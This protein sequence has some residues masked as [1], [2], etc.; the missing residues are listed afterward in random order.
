[1]SVIGVLGGMGPAATVDFLAKLV[2]LT[3]ARRDQEHLPVVVFGNP[4]IPDRSA[5]ILQ[6][7]PNPLPRLLAGIEFLNRAGVGLIAIPCNSSHHWY[8]DLSARSRVPILHIAQISVAAVRPEADDRVAV[9][10]TR[11]TIVSGFYARELEFQRIIRVPLDGALQDSVDACIQ[12]VKSGRLDSAVARLQ[13]AA[14]VAA[15]L[16]AT[17]L[18]MGCTE[19][20]VAAEIAG[21]LELKTVDSSLELAAAAVKFAIERGWN[22]PEH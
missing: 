22:V 13:S 2:R 14:A 20:C 16:G 3:P 18:I 17:A 4:Q 8:E 11:G 15:G 9:F 19:L 6:K 21:T 7:G 5:A 10:A 1:M 12:D